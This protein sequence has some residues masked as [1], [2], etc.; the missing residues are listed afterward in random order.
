MAT[1]NRFKKAVDIYNREIHSSLWFVHDMW[2]KYMDEYNTYGQQRMA[3]GRYYPK[4]DVRP[5]DKLQIWQYICALTLV[6]K[7]RG[8][9]D[10]KNLTVLEEAKGKIIPIK[11]YLADDIVEAKRD[12]I[13]N[14]VPVAGNKEKKG[15]T[16]LELMKKN[17][18]E[19]ER[20]TTEVK[21]IK[22]VPTPGFMSINPDDKKAWMIYWKGHKEEQPAMV[23]Y[24]QEV[25]NKRIERKRKHERNAA[26]NNKSN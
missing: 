13:G 23:Q 26:R 4:D 11:D 14:W 17:R 1:A 7:K 8:I 24:R 10:E 25:L 20:A 15:T 22:K 18:A 12:S 6:A 2:H 5:E 3:G 16:L 9:W 19:Q 21:K